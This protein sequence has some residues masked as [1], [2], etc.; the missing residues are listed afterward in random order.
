MAEKIGEG[1][2]KVQSEPVGGIDLRWGSGQMPESDMDQPFRRIDQKLRD[3][4]REAG[5][6]RRKARRSGIVK[7]TKAN[8]SGAPE[9][10]G[11]PTGWNQELTKPIETTANGTPV[12]RKV[13]STTGA[14]TKGHK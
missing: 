7:R 9:P 13:D 4:L 2:P 11:N 12:Y 14:I 8:L 5:G 10:I 1:L 6:D 3:D